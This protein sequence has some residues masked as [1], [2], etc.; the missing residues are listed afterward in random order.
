MVF[1]YLL[2][3]NWVL[4]QYTQKSQITQIKALPY[5]TRAFLL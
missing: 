1:P 2:L 5:R 4:S 3:L